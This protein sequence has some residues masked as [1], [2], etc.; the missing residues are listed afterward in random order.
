[1]STTEPNKPAESR[2]DERAEI[3]RAR[4]APAAEHFAARAVEQAPLVATR[5]ARLLEPLAGNERALDAGTGAGTLAMALAGLV[6][7]VVGCDIV[8][9]MLEAARE[10]SRGSSNLSFVEG[11]ILALPFESASFDIAGTLRTLHHLEF[12]ERALPELVRVTKRNGRLLVIDQIAPV[13][14][15]RA[16]E[17]DRFER[18]RDPSHVRTFA[19]REM[20]GLFERSGL[21]LVRHEIVSEERDLENFLDGAGCEGA[22]R[23]RLR[24][25]APGP[26][27]TIELGWYMLERRS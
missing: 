7:E 23:E 9:E 21:A 17:I 5:A 24:E 19:D 8:F 11:D 18:A 16:L 10:L 20:R 4:F 22:E 27:F 13:D 1:M 2:L 6:G 25:L 3:V 14:S 12:P 26:V 15:V